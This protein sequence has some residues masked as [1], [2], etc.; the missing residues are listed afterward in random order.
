MG[1]IQIPT[2]LLKGKSLQT[3]EA[4]ALANLADSHERRVEDVS[5]FRGELRRRTFRSITFANCSFARSRFEG[6]TFRKCSFTH[7][8]LTRTI[9]VECS[10]SECSFVDCDP[11]HARFIRCVVDPSEFAKCYTDD[12][13]WNKALIL[14]ANL[15]R[16]LENGGDGR[17][18]RV[19]EYH[20]RIW[21]RRRLYQLWKVHETSGPWPWFRSLLVAI[22]TGYGE[23][24]VYIGGWMLM[25][26][27]VMAAIYWRWFPFAVT[28]S[29]AGLGD[30]WYFSLKVFCAQGFDSQFVTAGLL[31]C[32]VTEFALGL[33][34]IALLVGSVT[35]KLS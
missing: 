22:L 1:S 10:F 30:Y 14:F 23:R 29:N 17:M 8:D 13:L 6:I 20:Y 5:F 18:A 12:D 19:A 7:V 27:T 33:I 2:G 34:L 3:W 26:I 28:A 16:G 24:P 4:V 21:E 11:Y 9:F 25:L 15:R 31:C 32:Q 35:R